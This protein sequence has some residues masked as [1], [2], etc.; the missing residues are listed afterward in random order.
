MVTNLFEYYLTQKKEILMKNRCLLLT[1]SLFITTLFQTGQTQKP[2]K[3][4]IIHKAHLAAG[5]YPQN[6]EILI[7]SIDDYLKIAQQEF[8]VAND[9]YKV[10]ALIVPHASHY[11]SG[12]AACTAYQSLLTSKNQKNTRINK[13]IILCPSHT[14]GFYGIALP[15]YD[16]YET[17]LGKIEVDQTSI[18]NLKKQNLFNEDEMVSNTEH[19]IEIQLPFLQQTISNFKIIPLIVGAITISDYDLVA[20]ELKKVID[21]TT[22]IVISSDFI[23]FGSNFNYKPFDKNILYQIKQTDSLAIQAINKQSFSEYNQVMINTK[24]TICGHGP[25]K[26]LLKLLEQ[27]LFGKINTQLSCYYTSPQLENA[28]KK[29]RNVINVKSLMK[30]VPDEKMQHSVSYASLI[31]NAQDLNELK[32][33]D[34]LTGYEKKTLLKLARNCIKN[35]LE[36]NPINEALLYPIKTLA[37]SQISGAFVTLNKKDDILRGCIGRIITTDPLYKTVAEMSKASAFKDSRFSP[38]TKEELKN[39]VIDITVLTPPQ[40]VENYNKIVLGKHGIILKKEGLS[41]VF[42]P[43]VPLSFGWNL[44]T[45]LE[46]LSLKAG[47]SKDDWKEECSFEVFEGFEIK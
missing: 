37:L 22:L 17:V 16:F 2:A 28:R 44:N 9:P 31:F 11:F 38:L 6:K 4:P 36:G 27:K 7:K 25:I 24:A 29:N 45:T 39:V 43:Q 34:L 23:H 46:H 19:A 32:K 20:Q 12:L 14:K 8:Y 42:L 26:I 47:L 18:N 1:L 3:T 40:K 33:E 21:D 5:W 41:A 13:V 35:A 15:N 10:K 30:H